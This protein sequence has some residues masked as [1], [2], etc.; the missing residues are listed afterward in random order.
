VRRS[1]RRAGLAAPSFGSAYAWLAEG[2]EGAAGTWF[3][4]VS[5]LPWRGRLVRFGRPEAPGF[6]RLAAE[7]E[8]APALPPSAEPLLR[9]VVDVLASGVARAVEDGL[10]ALEPVRR[11]L[12]GSIE[13]GAFLAFAYSLVVDAALGHLVRRGLVEVPPGEAVALRVED[14]VLAGA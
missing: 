1:L 8:A 3:A 6:E 7:P 13:D 4:R 5:V 14:P 11:R 9:Q 10:P 12:P 2:P